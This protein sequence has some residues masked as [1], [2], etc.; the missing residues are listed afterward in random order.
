MNNQTFIFSIIVVLLLSV[1]ASVTM[2]NTCTVSVLDDPTITQ[3]QETTVEKTQPIVETLIP[4]TVPAVEESNLTSAKK[5][6]I[7]I[8]EAFK[9]KQFTL[10][11]QGKELL[12]DVAQQIKPDS[13]VIVVGHSDRLGH[14]NFN[15]KL[16]KKRADAVV[17]YL[18]TKSNAEFRSYGAGSLIPSGKTYSCDGKRKALINCLSP[19]RRVEIEFVSMDN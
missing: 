13:V 7:K 16:S 9:F 12:D 18:K 3:P 6:V 14:T 2:N 8:D 5:I 17:K 4:K 15:K 10:T 1:L 19:D 11:N